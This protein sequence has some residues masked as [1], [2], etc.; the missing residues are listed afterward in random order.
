M[1]M[2]RASATL[3]FMSW[4][5]KYK[6]RFRSDTECAK[7]LRAEWRKEEKAEADELKD[8]SL[9]TKIGK[10]L[11][12]GDKTGWWA[13][14]PV[15]RRLFADLLDLDQDAIF[16][17]PAAAGLFSFP[18]FPRLA[19]LDAN[20]EPCRLWRDGWL[21]DVALSELRRPLARHVWISAP[22][23]AGK[24]LVVRYLQERHANE[25]LAVT[26][27]N[28]SAAA[29]HASTMLTLVVELEDVDDVD[30]SS[31]DV[32]TR[33]GRATIVLAPFG[34]PR[35]DDD[36]TYGAGTSAAALGWATADAA[37]SGDWRG[38]LIDWIDARLERAEWETKL[39]KE[40]VLRWLDQHDPRGELVG[41]P[42][43]LLALCADFDAHGPGEEGLA[44]RGARWL[45]DVG[46]GMLP[47]DTPGTW[48]THVAESA[49]A[50]LAKGH[51]N[52]TTHAFGTLDAKGWAD[53][54]PVPHRPIAEVDRP[55][56]V[57]AVGFFREGGLLRGSAH[58]LLPYPSWVMQGIVNEELASKFRKPRASG[59]GAAAADQSRQPIVDRALDAVSGGKFT[60]LL[61]DL[62]KLG[63]P[64]TLSEIGAVESALAALGRRLAREGQLLGSRD[65][66]AVNELMRHQLEA[67]EIHNGSRRPYTRRD[68]DE[69]LATAWAVSLH[70][71]APPG[72]SSGE[73]GW[74]L[75][76]WTPELDVASLPQQGFPTS[77]VQP[78]GASLHV[79]RLAA[80]SHLVV[81][82]LPCS[83]LSSEVPRLLLPAF[84]LAE[85]DWKLRPEHLEQLDGSWEV[86][87]LAS[88]GAKLTPQRRQ[89]AAERVWRLV[90]AGRGDGH[91]AAPVA[92]RID[93]LKRGHALLLDFILENLGTE[94]LRQTARVHGIHRWIAG[95]PRYPDATPRELV[96]L[97]RARR[98]AAVRGWLDGAAARGSNW[99]EARELVPLLDAQDLE[100]ALE[101]ARAGD[102]H[103]AA[104]FMSFVW[105]TAPWRA[106]DEADQAIANDLP[107]A[108]A[109]LRRAPR[110]EL[111]RIV[112]LIESGPTRPAWVTRWA[113]SRVLDSGAVAEQLF[114]LAKA[115]S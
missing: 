37:R 84:F 54:L 90:A 16:G 19:A 5:D 76:G 113:R 11:T 109:W 57:L 35:Q 14:H 105:R 22:P 100:L 2:R 48:R 83:E 49:F 29:V 71:P 87:H 89:I 28:L 52:D 40:H 58:G 25:F 63:A 91:S 55:G 70:V 95:T 102:G 1:E 43:D 62:A 66:A 13:K 56:S 97:L 77:Y 115:Q 75:P 9:A 60:A 20:E 46:I 80:L 44:E 74:E 6:Q 31:L 64:K 27:A 10:L 51:A 67:V 26:V 104:E 99:V 73:S 82:R 72:F 92:V 85:A 110:E 33:R 3:W 86:A 32:L 17:A 41:T 103:V 36:W 50:E 88:E 12:S 69:W 30:A 59:W 47:A 96:A 23:G 112:A 108:E 39:V 93:Q 68:A 101:L 106:R 45:R 7:R 15:V 111:P 81:T 114:R 94:E 98:Q 65:H 79:Q 78:F 53:L 18:E 21:L 107:S 8:S 34:F 42:G 61:R 24:S 38:R 4:Q